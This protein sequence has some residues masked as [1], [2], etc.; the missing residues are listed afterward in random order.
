LAQQTINVGSTP[1]DGTGD[2]L[3]S[4]MIKI[5]NNFSELYGNLF[6]NG[7]SSNIAVGNTPSSTNKL[8]IYSVLSNTSGSD[9]TAGQFIS[10][11]IANSA[12]ST[13]TDYR[14]LRV[15]VASNSQYKNA[16]VSNTSIIVGMSS[17]V[18]N[19]DSSSGGDAKATTMYGISA[20][21]YNYANGV[22]SNTVNTAYAA[23]FSFNQS[24]TAG[25]S[26]TVYG[27]RT[28]IGNLGNAASIANP[29]LYFGDYTGTTPT[30]SYGI[31]IID[32]NKNY[33]SGNTGIGNTDPNAKLQVTGTANISGAVVMSNTTSHIG[34]ATFSNTIAVTGAATLSTSLA[35]ST[36]TLTMGSS[37][38]GSANFANGF[39]RLP[40]GLLMQFGQ[41]LVNTTTAA[42]TF[43][44]VTG[45]NFVNVFS[46]SATT[47]TLASVVALTALSATSF[48]L[49]SN[50]AANV[51]VNWT[52]IG[53]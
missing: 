26:N 31:Y 44:V 27:V 34:A 30:N 24:A 3:R 11:P 18:Y 1:N 5:Q 49:V 12:V 13:T 28:I 47:N 6:T 51:A 39:A 41:L 9:T 19:G 29:I 35:V 20:D 37:N 52:A 22:S 16:T 17:D 33:L 25:V 4:A 36:N 53:K 42:Q 15:L 50:T 21:V 38:V 43:S 10:I 46:M 8:L 32:E 7:F 40:N 2:Q 14:G 48:T 45:T 23:N